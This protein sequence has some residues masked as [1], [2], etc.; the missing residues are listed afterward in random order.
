MTMPKL[1][2]IVPIY[3]S[4]KYLDKCLTSIKN[5]TLTD[6]ECILIDDGSKDKSFSICEHYELLD[7]RFKAIHK[8]NSGVADTRNLGIYLAK[9]E[10][11]GFVDSDDWIDPDRFQKAIDAGE[12]NNIDYVECSF[13]LWKD[14]KQYSQWNY[15]AGLFSIEDNMQLS[16]PKYDMGHSANK[17]YKSYL[18][19]DNNIKF[20]RC[21]LCE[22]LLFNIQIYTHYGKLLVIDEA[23][24]NYRRDNNTSLSKKYLNG[25]ERLLVINEY[26]RIV[27]MLSKTEKFKYIKE[28]FGKFVDNCLLKHS[29]PESIDFILPYVDNTDPNWQKL[30]CNYKYKT[31]DISEVNGN[32]RF[33]GDEH[34]LFKYIFRGIEKNMP[35]ISVVHLIVQSESQIPAWLDKSKVHIVYHDSYIPE[36][37]LP[38]FNSS[39]IEVCI[40]TIVGLAEK[41]LNSNDDIY[42]I[43][44]LKPK[45]F[46]SNEPATSNLPKFKY[47]TNPLKEDYL[48]TVWYKTFD[49]GIQLAKKVT[50][51]TIPLCN[52]NEWVAPPHVFIG[53]RKS[54]CLEAFNAA[55]DIIYASFSTFRESKNLSEY[56]Y[57]WYMV[58]TNNYVH[59][60]YHHSYEPIARANPRRIAKIVTNESTANPAKPVRAICINDTADEPKDWSSIIAAFNTIYPNKCSFEL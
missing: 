11:I 9:G 33:A 2:I 50:G 45:M 1:T 8:Y 30:Y 19:K 56:Y 16:S 31:E 44:V 32:F 26:D 35:W 6:W 21:N 41:Y 53:Y 18:I 40:P 22:D 60:M 54:L 7:S 42:P 58:L 55:K 13:K 38:V 5:Q 51:S 20:A 15:P 14:G 17:V 52:D 24:Y 57:F 12:A 36:E 28:N 43:A 25:K 47:D 10:W 23:L 27:R 37:A 29:D 39:V 3:N 4:E 59:D 48:E 34:G 49:N 46:F